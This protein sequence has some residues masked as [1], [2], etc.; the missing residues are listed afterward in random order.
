MV[1]PT[2]SVPFFFRTESLN[3]EGAIEILHTTPRAPD[4]DPV[5]NIEPAEN[6]HSNHIPGSPNTSE[7]S[8]SDGNVPR[9]PLRAVP[10]SWLYIHFPDAVHEAPS[11]R[12]GIRGSTNNH[13]C[14]ELSQVHSGLFAREQT[15]AILRSCLILMV[16]L[17]AAYDHLEAEVHIGSVLFASLLDM[18]FQIREERTFERCELYFPTVLDTIEDCLHPDYS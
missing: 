18:V 11:S 16:K 13:L 8:T 7:D 1:S 5:S 6:V 17:P 12:N 15:H 2:F 9:R 14:S 4:V 10:T 3:S